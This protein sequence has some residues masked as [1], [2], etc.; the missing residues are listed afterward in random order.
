MLTTMPLISPSSPFSTLS[1]ISIRPSPLNIL[2]TSTAIAPINTSDWPKRRISQLALRGCESRKIGRDS[3]CVRDRHGI[4][5]VDRSVE[6]DANVGRRRDCRGAPI[7][8]IGG[9]PGPGLAGNESRSEESALTSGLESFSPYPEGA[10]GSLSQWRPSSV[11]MGPEDSRFCSTVGWAF[12]EEGMTPQL[13]LNCLIS[14]QPVEVGHSPRHLS[15]HP[16]S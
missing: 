1:P 10:E 8:G 15:L 14:T 4:F 6:R 7:C 2:R 3:G 16:P 12:C 5:R 13:R 9:I 11:L